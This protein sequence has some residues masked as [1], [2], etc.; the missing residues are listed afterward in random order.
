MPTIP[1]PALAHNEFPIGAVLTVTCGTADRIFCNIADQNRILGYLTGQVPMPAD[2]QAYIDTCR[3]A[4][5]E[6]IPALK[7]VVA[8]TPG[9]P[10][11]V[12]LTWIDTQAK[13]ISPTITLEPITK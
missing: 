11:T 3:P 4:I 12:V 9:A 6:Q 10:D 7:T 1:A 8:P 5:L 2:T 13:N